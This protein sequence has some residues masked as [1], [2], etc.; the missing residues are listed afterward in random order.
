M[1]TEGKTGLWRASL[2]IAAGLL[3]VACGV[4]DRRDEDGYRSASKRGAAPPPTAEDGGEPGGSEG[5]FTWPGG[6]RD[7]AVLVSVEG[8][9]EIH[10]ALYPELAPKSVASFREL[11]SQDFFDGTTFH[12]VIPGFMVQGGD[13]NTRDDVIE[14][15]GQGGP[16][17]KL[18]DEFS[19]APHVR[20][21]VSMANSGRKNSGGSQFFIVHA[22]SPHLDGKYSL[23][24]R[25]V[26]GMEVVDAITEVERDDLGQWGPANRPI[27]NVVVE[28]V[29]II[30]DAPPMEADASKAAL[31]PA[32]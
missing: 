28:S 2:A 9:G 26:K 25:V 13:P 11:A 3:V 31:D 30:D 19:R 27:E 14:N 6:S 23:I 17:Y 16:D 18:P 29:R 22:N 12:R 20:G 1:R 5:R 24:G 15:D 21:T 8:L 10:I 7:I 4:E 32:A